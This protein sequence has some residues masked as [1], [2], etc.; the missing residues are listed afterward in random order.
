MMRLITVME[1]Q[2]F[3]QVM[4]LGWNDYIEQKK[5]GEAWKAVSRWKYCLIIIIINNQQDT[6]YC[7]KSCF[8]FVTLFYFILFSGNNFNLFS[9][10]SH[11]TIHSI[12]MMMMMIKFSWISWETR[13]NLFLFFVREINVS[14][15]SFWFA[16]ITRLFFNDYIKFLNCLQID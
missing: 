1:Q 13:K 3:D 14:F 5:Q 4:F 16:V 12:G 7:N 2:Q 10:S 6:D 15:A 8:S 11:L 9:F